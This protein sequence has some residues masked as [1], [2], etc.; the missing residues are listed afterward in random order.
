MSDNV[1]AQEGVLRELRVLI[2]SGQ[3]EPGQQVIQ[4]S[5]AAILGVSRVP[6][7]DA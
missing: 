4:D 3:L 5:L 1:T 7:R 6:L 2:A